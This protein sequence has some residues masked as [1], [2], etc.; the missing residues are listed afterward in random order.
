M[1]FE[2]VFNPFVVFL[3]VRRNLVNIDSGKTDKTV[4]RTRESSRDCSAAPSRKKRPEQD[5]HEYSSEEEAEKNQDFVR[6]DYKNWTGAKI[7]QSPK[8][9][10]SC[11][12]AS[13][14]QVGEKIINVWNGTFEDF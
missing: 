8:T 14:A 12:S 3:R 5:I 10:K 6:D 13:P 2:N 9:L 11:E 1:S 4:V 7:K